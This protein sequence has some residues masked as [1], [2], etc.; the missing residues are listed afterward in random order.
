MAARHPVIV[1]CLGTTFASIPGGTWTE[2]PR[3]AVVLPMM[4]PGHSELSGFL[5]A[6]VSPGRELDDSYR[7]FFDLLAIGIATAVANARAAEEEGERVAALADERLRT[8]EARFRT[9]ANSAPI[10]I[11]I[12]DSNGHN[13]FVNQTFLDFIGITPEEGEAFDWTSAV[14]PEDRA[15]Y[16]AEFRAALRERRPF[17]ARMRARRRDGCWRWLETRGS[18]QLDASGEVTAFVGCSPDITEILESQHALEEADRRKNE[19]LAVLAHELRN[20]LA[21]IM[22]GT[23][24][25]GVLRSSGTD[26]E[27]TRNMIVREVKQL[28]RLVDDLLDVTRLAVDRIV[29]RKE[30]LDMRAIVKRAIDTT[31]PFIDERRHRLVINLP[32]EPLPVEGDAARLAQVLWNLL[33]NAAKYTSKGGEIRIDAGA[34]GEHVQVRVSDHG[35]GIAAEDLP[36]VFDLFNRIERTQDHAEGGLGIGLM[37]TRGLVEMHGGSVHAWSEG[38]GRGSEF[39]V[40]LP[41]AASTGAGARSTTSSDSA[42]KPVRSRRVLLIDDNESFANAMTGL[43]RLMGHTVRTLYEGATAVATAREFEPHVVL[44]DIGLRGMRGY[45]IATEMRAD[46]ALAN[47]VIIA[48]SGYGQEQDKRHARQAGFDHYLTKPVDDTAL[49]YLIEST[50]VNA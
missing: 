9:M 8:F 30:P 13:T 15:A 50:V 3:T 34:S 28:S 23:R 20:P 22:S 24:S 2:P 1:E 18:P 5:V 12:T 42:R 45:D 47:V 46:P 31:Q 6:G 44:L 25:L 7:E 40:R 33:H 26:A 36:H 16:I 38:P 17:Q 27:K 4:R 48:M 19:F 41:L 11:W 43:L 35:I 14:H 21:S 32:G 29:L 37:L 10:I 39:V 49:A